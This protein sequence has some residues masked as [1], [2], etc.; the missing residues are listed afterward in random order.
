METSSLGS[1]NKMCYENEDKNFIVFSEVQNDEEHSNSQNIE[2]NEINFNLNESSQNN[3]SN[4]SEKENS[5]HSSS[6]KMMNISLK[7]IDPETKRRREEAL[8]KYCI[9]NLYQN[10][11]I[12]ISFSIQIKNLK[13]IRR[14]YLGDNIDINIFTHVIFELFDYIGKS[15]KI[16]FPNYHLTG[17]PDLEKVL[18]ETHNTKKEYYSKLVF[19]KNFNLKINDKFKFI[20]DVFNE[21]WEI[22]CKIES[23]LKVKDILTKSYKIEKDREAAFMKLKSLFR[24]ILITG[25][26]QS[27]PEGLG[28][29]RD[30]L[31]LLKYQKDPYHPVTMKYLEYFRELFSDDESEDFKLTIDYYL[32]D[33]DRDDLQIALGDINFLEFYTKEEKLLNQSKSQNSNHEDHENTFN[34]SLV[35]QDIIYFGNDKEQ[36]EEG[37]EDSI[38]EDFANL[39]VSAKSEEKLNESDLKFDMSQV[40]KSQISTKQ[41]NSKSSIDRSFN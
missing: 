5:F 6:S 2:E 9:K 23:I 7:S 3:Q 4:Y 18:F 34:A 15:W 1:K 40:I 27:P 36:E 25:E 35:T 26:N 32:H 16:K 13:I 14:I 31:K 22:D 20:Y 38:E 21:K 37:E 33:F 12:D 28:G 11:V 8:V 41:K 19:L 24:P 29:P 10:S 39:T 30:L 17:A